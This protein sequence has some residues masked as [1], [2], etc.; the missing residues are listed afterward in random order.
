MWEGKED[1]IKKDQQEHPEYWEVKKVIKVEM[2][3]YVRYW[4]TTAFGGIEVIDDL[5]KKLDGAM[6]VRVLLESVQDRTAWAEVQ[7]T[8][9]VNPSQN[10]AV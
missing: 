3:T 9:R 10:F 7:R 5:E 1:L 6:L 2:T 8:C 4:V